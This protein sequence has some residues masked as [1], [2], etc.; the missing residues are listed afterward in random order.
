MKKRIYTFREFVFEAYSALIE[1]KDTETIKDLVAKIKESDSDEVKSQEAY[2]EVMGW[3]ENEGPKKGQALIG[4]E[5]MIESLKYW[6]GDLS[7]ETSAS[8]ERDQISIGKL[9]DKANVDKVLKACDKAAETSEFTKFDIGLIT[10]AAEAIEKKIGELRKNGVQIG[11][12][13]PSTGSSYKTRTSSTG[14]PQYLGIIPFSGTEDKKPNPK[15][16]GKDIKSGNAKVFKI[17]YE[18]LKKNGI[19]SKI[20]ILNNKKYW[21][22]KAT[23]ME[24]EDKIKILEGIQEKAEKKNKDISDALKIEWMNK[25]IKQKYKEGESIIPLESLEKTSTLSFPESGEKAMT[26]FP[27]DKASVADIPEDFKTSLKSSLKELK[28]SLEKEGAEITSIKIQAISST[29]KVPSGYTSKTGKKGN[30]GLVEDRIQ[31]VKDLTLSLLK[32]NGMDVNVSYDETG[33]KPNQ[34]P[35]WGEAQRNDPKYGK[36]GARTEAYEEEYGKWRYSGVFISLTYKVEIPQETKFEFQEYKSVG[37]WVFNISWSKPKPPDI[38]KPRGGRI[39][40]GGLLP[41][42]GSTD[43]FTSFGK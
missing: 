28:D 5:S 18:S 40:S 4:T 33:K 26:F 8:F 32:E 27:E 7:G 23:V 14:D 39:R 30:E 21:I 11:A 9:K 15:Y 3:F 13:D 41:F 22:A 25:N 12:K 42:K 16:E 19:E 1:G 36:K 20:D 35:E 31:A 17:W 38:K 43:C 37:D 2:E 34:G 24:V 29:S 10:K 6:L